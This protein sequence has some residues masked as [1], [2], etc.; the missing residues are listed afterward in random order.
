MQQYTQN[1]LA[2]E[3]FLSPANG[4]VATRLNLGLP[5]LWGH[6]MITRSHALNIETLITKGTTWSYHWFQVIR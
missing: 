5:P 4:L 6:V 2:H 3:G 1:I